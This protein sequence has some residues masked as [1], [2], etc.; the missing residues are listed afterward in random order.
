L[1]VGTEKIVLIIGV[2]QLLCPGSG[3]FTVEEMNKD[4]TKNYWIQA[5]RQIRKPVCISLCS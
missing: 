2:Y 3:L 4:K 1:P 5:S